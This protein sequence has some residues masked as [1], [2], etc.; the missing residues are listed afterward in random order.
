MI[1]GI[2]SCD[3]PFQSA[4]RSR[5]RNRSNSKLPYYG[6][7]HAYDYY[8]LHPKFSDTIRSN[9]GNANKINKEQSELGGSQVIFRNGDLVRVEYDLEKNQISF[10]NTKNLSCVVIKNVAKPNRIQRCRLAVTIWDKN[11]SYSLQRCSI[12]HKKSDKYNLYAD[13][14]LPDFGRYECLPNTSLSTTRNYHPNSHNLWFDWADIFKLSNDCQTL[15][16]RIPTL[17][18]WHSYG[19]VYTKN[20]GEIVA[21]N[22]DGG[23]QPTRSVWTLIIYVD[24]D[25]GVETSVAVSNSVDTCEDSI[26]TDIE[27]KGGAKQV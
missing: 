14:C 5:K 9:G 17:H 8:G 11:N 26:C 20:I 10:W 23:N 15:S 7:N 18:F 16:A 2:N 24:G 21:M 12:T 27:Q 3:V 4:R 19:S 1:V 6:A 25:F 13:P 22:G